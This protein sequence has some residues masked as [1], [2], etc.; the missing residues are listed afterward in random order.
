MAMNLRKFPCTQLKF[1]KLPEKWRLEDDPVLLRPSVE[2]ERL[3]FRS[4]QGGLPTSSKWTSNP[5]N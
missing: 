1:S 3:N 2:G 4:V 5:Y